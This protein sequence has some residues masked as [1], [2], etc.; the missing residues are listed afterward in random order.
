MLIEGSD[1]VSRSTQIA[2]RSLT[3]TSSTVL[4]IEWHNLDMGK[5]Q[6]MGMSE[7][8]DEMFETISLV[9]IGFLGVS[10]VLN[11]L[12]DRASFKLWYKTADSIPG[13]DGWSDRSRPHSELINDLSGSLQNSFDNLNIMARPDQG[14]DNLKTFKDDIERE[15]GKLNA[16]L[17]ERGAAIH[18]IW[19]F[20]AFLLYFW[21]FSL[22][23]LI[24]C[25]AMFSVVA[26]DCLG[27]PNLVNTLPLLCSE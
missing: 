10:L 14:L 18:T 6:I 3:I 8:P 21:Y 25:A 27:D 4:T 9:M 19:S 24:S 12:S 23:L 5:F 7:F 13:R 16:A 11:W 15:L 22:P 2:A 17:E 1:V 26:G 20:G